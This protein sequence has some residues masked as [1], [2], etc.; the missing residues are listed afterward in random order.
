MMPM[1]QK[2][3]ETAAAA[4]QQILAQQQVLER[5]IIF[6]IEILNVGFWDESLSL[7]NLNL[8]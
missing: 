8:T 6:I 7:K 4:M 3:M 2:E 1:S 5:L